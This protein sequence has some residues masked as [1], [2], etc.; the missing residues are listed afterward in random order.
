MNSGKK[1]AENQASKG[2]V[3]TLTP[4]KARRIDLR[5]AHAIRRELGTLYRDARNWKVGT[6]DATR[7][8]YV[9]DMMRRAYETSVLQH[10]LEQY[11]KTINHNNED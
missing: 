10:R 3:P 11:E 7:L 2:N 1:S 6:Q 4:P 9:L 8:A 5:D